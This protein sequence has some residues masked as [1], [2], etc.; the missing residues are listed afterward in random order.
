MSRC[1]CGLPAPYDACCGRFHAGT[2]APTPELLMR[3]RYTAFAVGDAGY[4]LHTWH[5]TTRPSTVATGAGWLRLEVLE[6]SGGLLDVE[7][8]V[9]F[10]AH[11]RDRVVEERSRFVREGGRWMYVGP[12]RAQPVARPFRTG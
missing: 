10:R 7:G 9:W 8:E 1:P 12:A 2:A 4:L 3:S 6:S 11:A 5:P